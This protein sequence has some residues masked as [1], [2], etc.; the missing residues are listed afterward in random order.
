MVCK[1]CGFDFL[2]TCQNYWDWRNDI[3]SIA[4]YLDGFLLS[5]LG[6]ALHGNRGIKYLQI[7]IKLPNVKCVKRAIDIVMCNQ[8]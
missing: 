1:V 6:V 8:K 7:M 5:A 3:L 2:L 4:M